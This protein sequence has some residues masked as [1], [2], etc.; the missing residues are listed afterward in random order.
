MRF[1]A[2]KKG[3]GITAGRPEAQGDKQGYSQRS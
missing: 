1:L 2:L 3:L